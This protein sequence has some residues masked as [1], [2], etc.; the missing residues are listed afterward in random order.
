[1]AAIRTINEE[2][3]NEQTVTV[4]EDTIKTTF[5]VEVQALLDDFADVFPK[6]LPIGLPPQRELDHKFKLLPRAEP[7]HRAPTKCRRRG[8]MN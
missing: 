1:M 7:P 3:Q 6:N 5:P 4:N 2:Q 8:W